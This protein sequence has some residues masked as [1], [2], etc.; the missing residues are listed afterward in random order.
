VGAVCA[1]EHAAVFPDE[2]QSAA[3]G[4]RA[5]DQRSGIDE[6]AGASLRAREV[7]D[8]LRQ[9]AQ[10]RWDDVVVVPAPGV[11]GHSTG[12]S[13]AISRRRGRRGVAGAER[14]DAARAG[15]ELLWLT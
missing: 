15:E 11:S 4:G 13:R 3:L 2:A 10:T 12:G 8:S 7:D 6:L 1:G 5:V 14:Y 9:G